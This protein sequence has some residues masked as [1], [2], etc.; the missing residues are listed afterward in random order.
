MKLICVAP[1]KRGSAYY[2]EFE[3]WKV[4][5]HDHVQNNNIMNPTTFP[6]FIFTYFKQHF[7]LFDSCKVKV[8][9]QMNLFP[10]QKK[11]KIFFIFASFIEICKHCLVLSFKKY[12]N[13]F[14]YKN[15]LNKSEVGAVPIV[16]EFVS[17][18]VCPLTQGITDQSEQ[19]MTI[20][21]KPNFLTQIPEWY[22]FWRLYS[23]WVS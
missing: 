12:Y 16:I 8:T 15:V 2:W 14:S 9:I 5:Y 10:I 1:Y 3:F 11:P 4:R 23:Q 19:G 13:K 20:K 21:I 22:Q 18:I 7:I 17:H 6:I